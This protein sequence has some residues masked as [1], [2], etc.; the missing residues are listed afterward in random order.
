METRTRT[1]LLAFCL[2][3]FWIGVFVCWFAGPPVVWALTTLG[4]DACNGVSDAAI[5][6]QAWQNM[7]VIGLACG[8]YGLPIVF[9]V[10]MSFVQT[11]REPRPFPRAAVVLYLVSITMTAAI[12][13]GDAVGCG[14]GDLRAFPPFVSLLLSTVSV[15]SNVCLVVVSIFTARAYV[16]EPD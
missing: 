2:A 6:A 8:F 15:V 1:F 10:L 12:S 11:A 7:G 13:Y 14:G 9:L 5:R 4:S 16:M 3:G